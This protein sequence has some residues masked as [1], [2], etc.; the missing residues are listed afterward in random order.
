MAQS[1]VSVLQNPTQTA[2]QYLLIGR[3]VATRND[4]L[5]VLEDA[6]ASKWTVSHCDSEETRQ[7]GWK[8]VQAG[9]P[10]EGISKA[11]QGSLLSDKNDIT[12]D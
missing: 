8:L 11:I 12:I 6:T 2:N 5:A 1:I 7:I 3:F 9:N 10:Q 4:I